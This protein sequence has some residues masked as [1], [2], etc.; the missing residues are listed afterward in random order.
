MSLLVV[1]F[2]QMIV[3][4]V[5]VLAEHKCFSVSVVYGSNQA[6]QRVSLWRDMR[7]LLS[8]GSTAGVHMGDFN[9]VRRPDERHHGFDGGASADLMA[10]LRILICRRCLLKGFGTLDS[11]VG[12]VMVATKV[13]WAESLSIMLG[14]TCSGTQRGCVMLPA[15]MIIVLW[16]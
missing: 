2:P 16:Y 9:V 8:L 13:V 14:L 1:C 6:S 5:E 4:S 10:A 12:V 7:S 3:S 11:I 15:F